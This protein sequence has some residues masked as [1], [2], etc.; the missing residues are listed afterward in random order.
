MTAKRAMI[1]GGVGGLLGY[2][3]GWALYK[4][5]GTSTEIGHLLCA[6]WSGLGAMAAVMLASMDAK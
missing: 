6:V 1:S 4:S 5:A 3:F 2:G